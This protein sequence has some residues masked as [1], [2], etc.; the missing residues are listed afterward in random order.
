M[1]EKIIN[2]FFYKHN[3]K[4]ITYISKNYL[5]KKDFFNIYNVYNKSRIE[6]KLNSRGNK[7][8]EQSHITS[9]S[10]YFVDIKGLKNFNFYA[11]KVG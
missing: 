2:T 4:Q 11:H 9:L 10:K 8:K 6:K 7:I 5:E 1:V 3:K